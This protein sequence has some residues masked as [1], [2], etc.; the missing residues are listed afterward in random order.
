MN[1]F[2][3]LRPSRLHVS[4]ALAGLLGW[5]GM[6]SAQSILRYDP[7]GGE[8]NAQATSALA[9]GANPAMSAASPNARAASSLPG[10]QLQ[11]SA[12]GTSQQA[13]PELTQDMRRPAE[14]PKPSQFQRFV[15]ESTGKLLPVYGADL[16]AKPQTY[17]PVTNIA[18]PANYVL[19]PGDEVQLQ[20]WGAFDLSANFVV[21]AKGQITVPKV[22]AVTVAGVT[23][24]K[25][26][27]VLKAH[28][29]KVFTN[30]DLTA[31]VARLRSIQVYVVGQA[32]RPGTYTLSSLSTVVN[33]LFASGGPSPNGSM[34]AIQLK[35]A[36]QVVAQVDLYDFI[37]KGDRVQDAALQPG[38]VIVI[39]PAGPRVAVTGA[40][41]QEAIYEVK[42]ER[43]TVGDLLALGGGVPTLATPQK[44][45]LERIDPAAKEAPRQVQEVALNSSGLQ[46]TL[47]DGDVL[48][49]LPISPAFGNAVTLQGSVAQPLRHAWTSG[50]KVAD[51]IPE[52]EALI[53]RDYYRR[54]NALVQ[55]MPEAG[56]LLG[57]DGKPLPG[58]FP[59]PAPGARAQQ[60]QPGLATAGMDT[61]DK[62]QAAAMLSATDT[63]SQPQSM[64]S[65]TGQAQPG[66]GRAPKPQLLAVGDSPLMEQFSNR[67][68]QI[69]WDY[70]VIERLNKD[71][72]TPELIP[73][74]LGKAVLQRDPEHNLPLQPGDVVSVFGQNDLRLP[75]QRQSRLVRVEGE[76]A[77]PGVY[78][79]KPGETLR[80]LLERVGGLTPQAYVYGT[81]FTRE[82]VR[83]QQQK[84][85]DQLVSRLEAS[86]SSQS[87]A[88]IANLTGEAALRAA[89]ML[90]SQKQA[91]QQQIARL[92]SLRSN[93]RVALEMPTAS[94]ALASIPDIPLE[95]GDRVVVPSTPGFVSAFG[96][97]NNEN[98]FV[99][100][101]GR[102]VADVLHLAGVS[103]DAEPD[104]AFV[105]RADGTVVARKDR[106]SWFSSFESLALMPGD[107]VVVPQKVDRET[108][109]SF[110]TRVVK[111]WTQILAN[112]GLGMAALRSL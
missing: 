13:T 62:A 94:N 100:R 110:V 35:R 63:Q 31:T 85:L 105:L 56:P 67:R 89:T 9:T 11:R 29:A 103:E 23:V 2:L 90:E 18:P 43:A 37:A 39:P 78:Q 109:W 92:K 70:A 22:G 81:E 28:M 66:A 17:T 33:A 93:G 14:P 19:G 47:R 25:L 64:T 74:N 44:A 55:A 49:L 80:Q 98:V 6:A 104:Q 42:T 65:G 75:T 5:A 45:L 4:L 68:D 40:Y 84:N 21:D 16:F 95:D 48:T 36:G 79:A 91:Q 38:D 12:V 76:V 106:S 10:V 46:Q 1:V 97:V 26:E 101:P 52:R 112:L 32:Q 111:D 59:L 108:R 73:F 60:K 24:G 77:A 34:R 107:T 15:Q 50:M 86:M 53:S 61:A 27:P 57:P 30:I 71:T 58:T 102:T 72:L 20:V 69:N 83:Q 7:T 54:K 82:T 96:S 87:S 51:L 88:Q 99:H 3:N 8:A 41:D